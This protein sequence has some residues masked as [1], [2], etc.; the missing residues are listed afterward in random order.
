M[1]ELPLRGLNP[2]TR[3]IVS[4]Y[5]AGRGGTAHLEGDIDGKPK[6]N[7]DAR[8]LLRRERTVIFA[9]RLDLKGAASF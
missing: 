4:L 7:I 3:R 9:T 5:R 6:A 8:H 2:A 1:E